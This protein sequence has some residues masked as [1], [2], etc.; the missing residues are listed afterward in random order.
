MELCDLC[1]LGW[2][3]T[4]HLKMDIIFKLWTNFQLCLTNPILARDSTKLKQKII[5]A[6]RKNN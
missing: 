1:E 6:E 3:K 4:S 2:S 5:K